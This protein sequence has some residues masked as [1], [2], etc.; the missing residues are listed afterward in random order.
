MRCSIPINAPCLTDFPDR[1]NPR[2]TPHPGHPVIQPHQC[3]F[4]RG[5]DCQSAVPQVANLR[6]GRLPIGATAVCSIAPKRHL[7]R[8]GSAEGQP[9]V[10]LSQTGASNR[11][12]GGENCPSSWRPTSV[13]DP[14]RQTP[15]TR[16]CSRGNDEPGSVEPPGPTCHVQN[17]STAAAS[18][19]RV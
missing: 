5:A 11:P 12:A 8:R 18:P 6:Y 13:E 17:R 14:Q 15:S 7:P 16:G 19:E 3:S 1:V 10:K 9:S 4:P 2:G